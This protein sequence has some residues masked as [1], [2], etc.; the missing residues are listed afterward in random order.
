ML[1]RHQRVY[2]LA[3]EQYVVPVRQLLDC[4]RLDA[5]ARRALWMW[6]LE[7]RRRLPMAGRLS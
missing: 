5:R 2:T 3:D 1:E 4:A 7:D 6:A